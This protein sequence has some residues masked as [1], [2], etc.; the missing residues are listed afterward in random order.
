MH[1]DEFVKKIAAQN[2]SCGLCVFTCNGTD[3]YVNHMIGFHRKTMH[4]CLVNDCYRAFESQN[5]LRNHCKTK[6]QN[7][8]K[9]LICDLVCL[10]PDLLQTHQNSHKQGAKK[11]MCT[12]C[13][14]AFTRPDD[15]KRHTT[16]NCPHNPDRVIRC[17][18]CTAMNQN[19]DVPGAEQGLVRHLQSEHGLLGDFVCLWCHKLFNTEKKREKHNQFCTKTHPDKVC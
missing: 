13:G 14:K 7:E 11:Y 9:C 17:K 16:F 5:G 1:Y 2:Y 18:L 6:H 10:S 19:A 12:P 4:C 3:E 8:L 15:A